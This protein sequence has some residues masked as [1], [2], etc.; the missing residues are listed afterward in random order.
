MERVISLLNAIAEQTANG[1]SG[2][3]GTGNSYTKTQSDER[4]AQK[5]EIT[6]LGLELSE[7]KESMGGGTPSLV[8]Y[9]TEYAL[10]D[11]SDTFTKEK[12]KSMKDVEPFFCT[13]H[14]DGL[15]ATFSTCIIHDRTFLDFFE[16][17]AIEVGIGEVNIFAA[18]MIDMGT[19]FVAF[20]EE[21][22][23]LLGM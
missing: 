15:P 21:G 20:C 14:R 11:Y 22:V 5:T 3:G 6:Q 7:I 4:Y 17:L 19:Y 8:L 13:L 2:G 9:D 10:Y 18:A 16:N 23:A 1:V 12:V